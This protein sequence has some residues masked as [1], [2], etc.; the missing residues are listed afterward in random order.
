MNRFS[1]LRLDTVTLAAFCCL[2]PLVVIP[3]AIQYGIGSLAEMGPGLFPAMVSVLLAGMGLVIL[4]L[5]GRDLDAEEPPAQHDAVVVPPPSGPV[6]PLVVARVLGCITLAVAAFALLIESLGL[7]LSTLALV[8]VAS[9]AR[10]G[11]AFRQAAMLAV[12]LTLFCCLVFGTLLGP[13]IRL[14]PAFR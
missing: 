13:E 1:R 3:E 12:G 4:V 6:G 5:N 11:T 10:R 9:L 8:F 7:A 14:L 2:A